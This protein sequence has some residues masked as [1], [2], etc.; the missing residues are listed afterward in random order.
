M[1]S[2]RALIRRLRSPRRIE[3]RQAAEELAS[4]AS[5]GTDADRA[6]MVAEGGIPAL[7]DALRG[8]FVPVQAV[9]ALAL[10]SLVQGNDSAQAHSAAADAIPLLVELLSSPSADE[11]CV[12]NAVFSLEMLAQGRPDCCAAIVAAGG[13]AALVRYCGSS[14]AVVRYDA[15]IALHLLS[16]Q[17][18]CRAPLAAAGAFQALVHVMQVGVRRVCVGV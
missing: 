17:D 4:L 15:C 2:V 11:P 6:R 13:H 14:D 16:C 9:A 5:D 8:G 10:A 7:L 12:A 3:Q 18:S 1:S